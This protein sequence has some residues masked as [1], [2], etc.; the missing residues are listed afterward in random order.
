[1]KLDQISRPV[2]HDRNWGGRAHRDQQSAVPNLGQSLWGRQDATKERARGSCC[3]FWL[4]W[5]FLG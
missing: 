2:L 1:M 3:G 4:C 5:H